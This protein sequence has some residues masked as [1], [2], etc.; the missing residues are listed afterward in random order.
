MRQ[1]A[2]T[3]QGGGV[4]QDTKKAGEKT[5]DAA[6]ATGHDVK[7]GTTKALS[8]DQEGHQESLA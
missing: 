7:K 1:D 4:K 5:K 8:R 2:P 6:K 3:N